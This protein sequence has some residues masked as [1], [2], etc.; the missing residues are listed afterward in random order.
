VHKEGKEHKVLKV[1]KVLKELILEPKGPKVS[2][3]L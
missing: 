1:L 3:V 2:K